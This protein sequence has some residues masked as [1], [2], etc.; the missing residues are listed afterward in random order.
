MKTVT[1]PFTGRF[2]NLLFQWAYIR[3]F[4]EQN[5]YEL[6]LPEWIGEKI[7]NIPK[8]RRPVGFPIDL[9]LPEDTHQRQSSLIYTRKQVRE[10]FAIRPEILAKLRALDE[11]RKHVLLNVRQGR[12]YTDAG[13]VTLSVES[14]INACANLGYDNPNDVEWETDLNPMMLPDFTGDI[15]ASGLCTT[16]VGLPSFYRLM[17]APVLFR[18]NSSFSWW[19]STL[20]DGVIYSPVIKGIQ[21]GVPNQ[22]C[23]NFILGNWPVCCDNHPNTDLHLKEL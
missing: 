14:Y 18:A 1:M 15:S 11:N 20:S 7:F 23:D 10:W 6:C 9:I 2:G 21:G 12:D 13:L 3:A 17:T 5:G 19:A 22:R 4:A 8:A 16:W